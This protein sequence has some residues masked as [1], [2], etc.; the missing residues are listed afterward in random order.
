[1]SLA[2]KQKGLSK[3]L[4]KMSKT[5]YTRK[6]LR[7]IVVNKCL[8]FT[9]NSEVFDLGPISTA[10]VKAGQSRCLALSRLT[11]WSIHGQPVARIHFYHEQMISFRP[12]DDRYMD[13]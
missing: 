4:R 10:A 9:L 6:L 8:G 5:R 12:F 3:V 11:S 13:A 1:M 2:L 7:V